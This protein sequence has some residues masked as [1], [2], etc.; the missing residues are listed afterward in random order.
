MGSNAEQKSVWSSNPDAPPSG[1]TADASVTR[2]GPRVPLGA[3]LHNLQDGAQLSE[4]L[5][6]LREVIRGL[7]RAGLEHAAGR[8]NN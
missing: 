3:L 4:V 1:W 7:A 8:R 5:K 2:G 6:W